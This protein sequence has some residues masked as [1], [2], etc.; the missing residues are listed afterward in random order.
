M[1]RILVVDDQSALRSAFVEMLKSAN[2]EVSEASD[3]RATTMV[4]DEAYDLVL[5]DLRMGDTDGLRA[6]GA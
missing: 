4:R 6:F 5:T 2:H 1:A 3:D